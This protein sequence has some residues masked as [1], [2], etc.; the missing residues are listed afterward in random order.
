MEGSVSQF[1]DIGPSF[2]LSKNVEIEV[3]KKCKKLPVF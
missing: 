2:N 1:F 3:Q